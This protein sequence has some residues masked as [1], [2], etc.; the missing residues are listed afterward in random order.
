M[1]R[2]RVDLEFSS[3]LCRYRDVARPAIARVLGAG[4]TV[5]HALARRR[6]HEQG[7]ENSCRTLRNVVIVSWA[8]NLGS[9]LLGFVIPTHPG[10]RLSSQAKLQYHQPE[11][12]L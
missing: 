6:P 9:I 5:R 1:K 11:G 12:G 8:A 7:G 10:V 3:R 2:T 4:T